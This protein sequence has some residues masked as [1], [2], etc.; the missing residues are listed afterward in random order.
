M[1]ADYY[2]LLGVER[3]CNDG[4]LKSAFRKMAM[5]Y[6]PDK[7]PGNGEAE[8]KFIEINEAY[9]V[10]KDPQ[11]R[12][13]YDRFGHSAFSGG[14]AGGFGG[15]GGGGFADIFED[16]FGEMMGGARSA[17]S[18]FAAARGADLSY[19]MEISLEEAYHGK[20]AQI[21]VPSSIACEACGGSG[22]KAGTKPQECKTCRG[23][24]RIRAAQGFF[25]V[26]RACPECRG[27]GQIIKDPCPECRGRGKQKTERR[28]TVNIPAG[29]E[30]GTRIRLSGEG[31]AG[32]RGGPNGDLYIF[33]SVLPHEFFERDG[34]NLFC[35]MPV[36]MVTAALGGNFEVSSLDGGKTQVKI[37]EGTQN[38]TR[39][40]LKG[41][42]MPHLRKP[43]QL[44]D[45]YIQIQVEVPQKLSKKQKELLQEFDKNSGK[46]NSPKSH[47][48]LTRMKE[49]FSA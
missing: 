8:R 23:S 10:L 28:L 31:E 41:K 4:T 33:L 21:R 27:Q 13:A 44:G 12:A 19:S 9:E 46:E 2:E 40:R 18:P 36:S 20:E 48:F 30:D 45:M 25:A 24:G 22:A 43:A 37:P 14:G 7:N 17:R 3:D 11:K 35:H 15:F 29:V 16:I 39:F 42:G 34:A 47:G 6:H 38:E 32:A 1:K 26:E 5:R 49:F